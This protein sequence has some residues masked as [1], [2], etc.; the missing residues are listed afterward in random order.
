MTV[1]SDWRDCEVLVFDVEGTLVDAASPTLHCWQDTLRAAGYEVAIDALQRLSGMDSVEMLRQLVPEVG[2]K[3]REQLI[4]DQGERYRMHYLPKVRPFEGVC[5]LFLSLKAKGH[6]LALATDCASDELEHYLGLIGVRDLLDATA[7]G[8]DVV[9][10]KPAPNLPALALRRAQGATG[11]M[12]GD[13][14]FD[15]QSAC[16]ARLRAVGVLTGGFREADLLQAGCAAVYADIAA[17][18]AT[19]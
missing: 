2:K 8:D 17:L 19:I 13:T 1:T 15:A 16:S 18:R 12:V 5:A 14:P 11:V 4:K 6:K 10:G 9:L 7:S 3:D